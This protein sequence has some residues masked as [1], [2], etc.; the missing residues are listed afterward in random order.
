[1][2]PSNFKCFC[3]VPLPALP[4]LCFFAENLVKGGWHCG[5]ARAAP[6]AILGSHVQCN[7]KTWMLLIAPC[8]HAEGEGGVSGAS[9]CLILGYWRHLKRGVVHG[10]SPTA[11]TSFCLSNKYLNE[12]TKYLKNKVKLDS[13]LGDT[14]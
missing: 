7:C 3:S 6:L 11:V 12:Q 10:Q 5:T 2:C 4:P 1:M 9:A 8:P 14:C 13:S